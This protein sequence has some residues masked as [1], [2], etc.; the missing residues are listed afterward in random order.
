MFL[1]DKKAAVSS[2]PLMQVPPAP[3]KQTLGLTQRFLVLQLRPLAKKPMTLEVSMLSLKDK[4]QR[5]RLHLS[6]KFRSV[7]VHQMHVQVPL[8][9]LL[10][11]DTWTNCILD[12]AALT[13]FF[14]RNNDFGSI[15][16]IALHSGCRLRVRPCCPPI[17]PLFEVVALVH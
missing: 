10:P 13:S 16:S 7:E 8:A 17:T 6:D 11:P 4:G 5:Y 15:D 12:V 2:A 3:S 9:G 1:L 14:F